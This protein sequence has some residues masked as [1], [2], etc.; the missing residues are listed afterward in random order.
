[1]SGTKTSPRRSRLPLPPGPRFWT[2]FGFMAEMRRGALPF[3]ERLQREYGDI[4]CIHA[5]PFKTFLLLRPD[6]V[7]H[8]LIDNHKNYW[9]GV[10]FQKLSRFGGNGLLFSDG[11]HWKRQRRLATPAFQKKS[12]EAM[13]AMMVDATQDLLKRW[14]ERSD[15]DAPFDVAPEMS[16]LALDIV[17]RAMFGT[18]ILDRADAFQRSVNE[19]LAFVNHLINTF[20]PLPMWVPTRRNRHAQKVRGEIEEVIGQIIRARRSSGDR[21]DDLLSMLLS[22]RDEETGEGM[23]DQELLDEMG[24][25]INAG[26]ETT[27]IALAWTFYLLGHNR[28]AFDQ[29]RQEVEYVLEG[30]SP[31]FEDVPRLDFTRRVFQESLRLFPPAWATARQAYADDE[32]DGFRIPRNATITVSPWITQRH[33][34]FWEDPERFDPDRFL[35]ERCEGRPPLAYFPFGAGGRRCIGEGFALLEATLVLATLVQ[36]VDVEAV[37]G[38]VPVPDPIFTLRPGGGVMVTARP[39]RG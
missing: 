14:E 19:A 22:A 3:L 11:E 35:P 16:K 4:V 10:L 2:P 33:P 38:H 28:P 7:K 25:F 15:V 1:M 6:Y 23:T 37:P 8:V 12:L 5:G 39:R 32:I 13:S 29:L 24:T 17:C 9:K 18:D 26:H 36:R 27:G 31:T 20:F 34:D 21:R 30:R